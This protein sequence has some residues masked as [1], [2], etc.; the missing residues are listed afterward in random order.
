MRG[1]LES[2]MNQLSG[3]RIQPKRLDFPCL[4]QSLETYYIFRIS[5]EISLL[6]VARSNI[7]ICYCLLGHSKL[8]NFLLTL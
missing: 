8:G 1:I 6:F 3:E 7:K 4:N 5:P 2:E